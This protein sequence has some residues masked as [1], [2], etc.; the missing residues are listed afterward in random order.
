MAE[1]SRRR[2]RRG[3]RSWPRA[4]RWR[5]RRPFPPLAATTAASVDMDLATGLRSP[6]ARVRGLA[7]AAQCRKP[8]FQPDEY[9]PGRARRKSWRST[10]RRSWARSARSSLPTGTR[11]PTTSPCGRWPPD[12]GACCS[13]DVSHVYNDTGDSAQS[14]SGS[15]PAPLAPGRPRSPGRTQRVLTVRSRA[16]RSPTS[17]SSRSSRPCVRL[18]GEMFD[19]A[20]MRSIIAAGPVAAASAFHLDGRAPVHLRPPAPGSLPPSTRRC[21]TPCVS[22]RSTWGAQRRDPRWPGDVDRRP[23]HVRCASGGALVV[24][25]GRSRWSRATRLTGSW[26]ACAAAS[27]SRA[28]AGR[29]AG[30]FPVG[31]RAC[32]QRHQRAGLRGGLEA[33][34]W[35]SSARCGSAASSCHPRTRTACS[36]RR[37]TRRG[38]GGRAPSWPRRS[39]AL[40]R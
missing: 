38:P 37:S 17:A 7:G 3:R 20:Q 40:S 21:S 13:R 23:F 36:S 28:A 18:H 39:E 34:R 24:S 30:A 11:W 10:S 8:P 4:R 25:L 15:Q 22:P 32:P 14:L 12:A 26:T 33:I 27:P 31:D 5:Q 9:R 35:P 6:R 29:L 16:G 2:S 19:L 1:I